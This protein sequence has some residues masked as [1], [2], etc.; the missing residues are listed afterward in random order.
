[1]S[2][3]WFRVLLDWN[4]ALDDF[5]LPVRYLLTALVVAMGAMGIIFFFTG[6]KTRR[7]DSEKGNREMSAGIMLIMVIAVFLFIVFG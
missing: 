4:Y 3:R 6:L 5:W 7:I 2:V 1:M